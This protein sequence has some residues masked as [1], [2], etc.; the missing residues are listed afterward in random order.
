MLIACLIRACSLFV[1]KFN[2]TNATIPNYTVSGTQ[3]KCNGTFPRTTNKRV[4]LINL[5]NTNCVNINCGV[6]WRK[7]YSVKPCSQLCC[8]PCAL[9]VYKGCFT[10][11]ENVVL[12]RQNYNMVRK[13]TKMESSRLIPTTGVS[14]C[15]PKSRPTGTS[16]FFF[17]PIRKKQ[18]P[19]G[20]DQTSVLRL[21]TPQLLGNHGVQG[22]QS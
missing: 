9:S 15:A 12:S 7:G 17:A 18:P 8:T 11:K 4:L 16:L 2:Q 10:K 1:E 21:A 22:H 14:K 6:Y 20:L 19:H 5:A 3:S 13:L